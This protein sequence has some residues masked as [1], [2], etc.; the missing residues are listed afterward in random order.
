MTE[1]QPIRTALKA[2]NPGIVDGDYREITD[3]P[4]DVCELHWEQHQCDYCHDGGRIRVTQDRRSPEFGISQPCP[5]CVGAVDGVEPEQ[6]ERTDQRMRIPRAFADADVARLDR[7]QRDA[8][9]E[10][11]GEYPSQPMLVLYG[12][13]G[14]GKTYAAVVALRESYHRT[15][16]RGAFWPVIDLLE[17]YRAT[18]DADRAVESVATIDAE[19]RR[20]HLLVLDDLG[21]QKSSEW[22]EQQLFR[23]IDERHR[24]RKPLI[25]TT[26]TPP[27]NLDAALFSRLFGSTSQVVEFQG[28][29]RRMA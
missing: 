17:R 24:E 28:A 15:G 19:M 5:Q 11:V 27:E 8:I 12:N 13:V 25:V 6:P 21:K 7:Q 14:A 16:K 23:L 10:I 1:L 2:L 18:F 29:D 3:W 4:D 26:N 20:T 9:T 22:A